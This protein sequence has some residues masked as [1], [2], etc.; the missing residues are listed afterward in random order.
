MPE[1][2]IVQEAA[3]PPRCKFIL[4]EIPVTFIIQPGSIFILISPQLENLPN[5]WHSHAK[6]HHRMSLEI[7]THLWASFATFLLKVGA[8]WINPALDFYNYDCWTNVL[9]SPFQPIRLSSVF[10][11]LSSLSVSFARLLSIYLSLFIWTR[12]HHPNRSRIW[13]K[14]SV[15]F[16][17]WSL[18]KKILTQI[19]RTNSGRLWEYISTHTQCLCVCVCRKHVAGSNN[20]IQ[21]LWS[22]VNPTLRQS[23]SHHM[24]RTTWSPW[25]NVMQKVSLIM[26]HVKY[27]WQTTTMSAQQTYRM[28][29]YICIYTVRVIWEWCT[30]FRIFFGDGDIF[31]FVLSSSYIRT[32]ENI[33]QTCL[34]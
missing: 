24:T 28:W 16:P 10:Y 21:N 25:N 29:L 12:H 14:V 8:T 19:D 13:R 2:A 1:N 20:D 30:S 18:D 31:V 6:K 9:V 34:Q 26:R 5:L 32:H 15:S 17:F 22:F 4:P 11:H 23:N 3:S 7:I 27:L 33:M